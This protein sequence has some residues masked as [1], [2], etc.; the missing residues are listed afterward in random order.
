MWDKNVLN[1]LL[2]R[3]SSCTRYKIFMQNIH[4]GLNCLG[5]CISC[6]F[7]IQSRP[8]DFFVC[9]WCIDYRSRIS[10]RV[11]FLRKTCKYFCKVITMYEIF[12][13][14]IYY[15]Q[16]I[17]S[18][19]VTVIHFTNQKRYRNN[20]TLQYYADRYSLL[21]QCIIARLCKRYA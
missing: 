17:I 7:I 10:L 14:W 16:L 3:W 13:F 20:L 18:N 9:P 21:A 11:K 19:V 8:I 6:I 4:Y 2:I 15:P 1:V 5:Y 12:D